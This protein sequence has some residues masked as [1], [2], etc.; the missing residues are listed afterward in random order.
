MR[1]LA[2]ALSL[3]IMVAAVGG[4]IWYESQPTTVAIPLET[5]DEISY[6]PLTY[7]DKETTIDEEVETTQVQRSELDLT[8]PDVTLE[9]HG[10]N[11]DDVTLIEKISQPQHLD[12]LPEDVRSAIMGCPGVTDRDMVVQVQSHLELHSTLATDINVDYKTLLQP[13]LFEF[14]DGLDCDEGSVVHHLK[15]GTNSKITYWV[16][17]SG[18]VTPDHPDGNFADGSWSLNGIGLTL[19]NMEPADWK[20][21]GP[22]VA[23]CNYLLGEQAK[24]WLAGSSPADQDDCR[25]A[26]TPET[27]YGNR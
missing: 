25:P 21:W 3:L 27:A 15:P 26:D 4:I 7:Y 8:T 11:G 5:T 12:A 23:Q 2:S 20:L 22:R 13:A 6:D 17:L 14:S 18:V 1:K 24:I 9:V 10:V 16:A 19:P